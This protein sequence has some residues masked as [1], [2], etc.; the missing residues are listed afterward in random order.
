MGV[1]T[2]ASLNDADKGKN[3]FYDGGLSIRK[4]KV[5]LKGR[6][7]WL[8]MMTT[9]KGYQTP[10]LRKKRLVVMTATKGHQTPLPNQGTVSQQLLLS[11]Y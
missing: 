5:F 11:K 2:M 9:P 7:G 1:E 10:L 3:N 6:R 4:G 8:V